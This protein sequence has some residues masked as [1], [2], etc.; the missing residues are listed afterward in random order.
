MRTCTQCFITF[1]LVIKMHSILRLYNLH[2][3]KTYWCSMY[4]LN[5]WLEKAIAASL[6]LAGLYKVGMLGKVMKDL[7]LFSFPGD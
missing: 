5:E 6:Y 7:C 4:Y 1:E 3:S 2:S